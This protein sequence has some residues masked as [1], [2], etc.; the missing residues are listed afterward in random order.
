MSHQINFYLTSSDLDVFESDLR[1][2]GNVIF[3]ADRSPT[4]R[5]VI[6]QSLAFGPEETFSKVH[7]VRPQD[8][9]EVVANFAPK[10]SEWFL[11]SM[12][13]P[14]IEL[15]RGRLKGR[16]LK[17][18]RLFFQDGYYGPDRQWKSKPLDFVRWAKS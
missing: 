1:S 5:A 9:E 16:Q 4:E 3:L 15:S 13:S 10:R 11:D 6:I 7:L 17:R 18:G 2:T 8:L 12:R 14:V